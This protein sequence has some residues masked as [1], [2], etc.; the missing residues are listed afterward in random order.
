MIL[1]QL[2]VENHLKKLKCESCVKTGM[3]GPKL[4]SEQVFIITSCDISNAK[5]N[6]ENWSYS[7]TWSWLGLQL[8]IGLSTSKDATHEVA[9]EIQISTSKNNEN[10]KISSDK[11]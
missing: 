1:K 8:I 3:K 9:A 6:V 5:Q 11:L 10:I 7:R 2:T 4:D